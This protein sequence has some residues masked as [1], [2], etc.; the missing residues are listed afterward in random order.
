MCVP[1][2]PRYLVF[3]A[4]ARSQDRATRSGHFPS[5]PDEPTGSPPPCG[6]PTGETCRC[7]TNLLP[8]IYSFIDF[9]VLTNLCPEGSTCSKGLRSFRTTSYPTP[10]V[11]EKTSSKTTIPS[12]GVTAESR[13][14]STCAMLEQQ[15][16][17]ASS[18]LASTKVKHE[19]QV[20]PSEALHNLKTQQ[21]SLK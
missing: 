1:T 21:W 15:S 18:Q 20:P 14:R 3:P 7:N 9:S 12:N 11:D 13:Q 4:A 19:T 10:H 16:K 8:W 6:W 17:A 2:G 5:H